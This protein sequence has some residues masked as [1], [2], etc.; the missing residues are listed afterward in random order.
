VGR[1]AF[2]GLT[3]TIRNLGRFSGLAILG[4]LTLMTPLA[5][6][7]ALVGMLG[8]VSTAAV[9]VMARGLPRT[10]E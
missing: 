3:G 7:L 1:S 5:G 6:A 2:F 8:I 10:P 9:P 4:G